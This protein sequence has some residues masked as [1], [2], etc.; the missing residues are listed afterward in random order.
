MSPNIM[1]ISPSVCG[2]MQGH[3]ETSQSDC[4]HGV[5][6]R[7]PENHFNTHSRQDSNLLLAMASGVV[8]L[9]SLVGMV[10]AEL[11]ATC[12]HHVAFEQAI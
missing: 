1:G 3:P 10:R 11:A 7:A 9:F 8:P 12:K 6:L 5:I 2:H 4:W